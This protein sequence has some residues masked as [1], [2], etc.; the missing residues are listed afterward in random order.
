[1]RPVV[2]LL[3]P[4]EV[5]SRHLTKTLYICSNCRQEF[6]PRS[7][8]N[9]QARRNASG[10]TPFTEKVRRRI[11]GTDNPPGLKDPYGGEGVIEK[12]WKKRDKEQSSSA[13][14]TAVEQK[15]EAEEEDFDLNP[16]QY[17]PATTIDGLERMGH[18]GRWS[19]FPPTEDDEY[20]G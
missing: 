6:L 5:P 16:Q 4:L 3:Q 15:V 12:A 7:L 18:L 9:P 2:R 17:V 11:W 20:V 19:D 8:V 14:A 1:M 13:S 10:N